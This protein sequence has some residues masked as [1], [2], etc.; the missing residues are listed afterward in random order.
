[1]AL[2][3]TFIVMVIPGFCA[4]AIFDKLQNLKYTKCRLAES[5]M[6]TSVNFDI[7]LLDCIYKCNKMQTCKSF[8]YHAQ[9]HV[10]AFYTREDLDTDDCDHQPVWYGLVED[11]PRIVCGSDVS[12]RVCTLSQCPKT[13]VDATAMTIL[14]NMDTEGKTRR[15]LNHNNRQT[16]VEK[17]SNRNWVTLPDTTQSLRSQI[18]TVD[19][20][21]LTFYQNQMFG[22]S[23]NNGVLASSNDS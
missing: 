6:I 23:F 20:S 3:K 22:Q 11:Y 21:Q 12:F 8:L 2:Y 15:L 14:G 18:V 19:T 9:M 4:S 17:C 5:D 7:T 16:Q 13:I 10:C 1:M